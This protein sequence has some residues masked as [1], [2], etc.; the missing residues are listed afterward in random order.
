MAKRPNG[1]IRNSIRKEALVNLVY[2]D[3]LNGAVYSNLVDKLMNDYWEKGYNYTE[4]GAH[5]IVMFARRKMK[6]DWEDDLPNLKAKVYNILNDIYAECRE[7]KDR[8]N[9]LKSIDYINKLTGLYAPEK[10]DM[11][12]DSEVIIDFKFNED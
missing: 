1:P 10:V 8:M 12:V 6:K 11:K 4:S 3:I 5:E 9:A 7:S 2:N